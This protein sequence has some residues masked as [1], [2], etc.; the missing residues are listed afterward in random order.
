MERIN[1]Q[2]ANSLSNTYDYFFE[3]HIK[4]ETSLA[5][6]IEIYNYKRDYLKTWV[7]KSK[8]KFLETIDT[9]ENINDG[10]GIFVPNPEFNQPRRKYFVPRHFTKKPG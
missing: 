3:Q 4:H 10:T 7:P 1:Q 8:V 6:Q 9:R 2:T 5:F